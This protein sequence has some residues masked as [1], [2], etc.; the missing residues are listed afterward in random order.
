[1]A[2]RQIEKLMKR[3]ELKKAGIQAIGP[4]SKGSI[5]ERWFTCGN[6][7]CGCRKEPREKHGPYY[8][9]SWKEKKKTI[10]RYVSR[11]NISTYQKWLNNRQELMRVI[12]EMLDIS[13][14]IMD[15]MEGKK[16]AKKD[17]MVKPKRET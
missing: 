15:R 16:K 7:N 17:L 3:Y 12:E 1:M 8:Q 14:Q 10:S 4:I 9:L 13:R 5:T 6:K 2:D 11:E